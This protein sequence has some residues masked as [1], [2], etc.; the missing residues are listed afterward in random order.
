MKR[1]IIAGLALAVTAG[2][3]GLP[4]AHATFP[5]RN[6]RLVVQA[7]VDDT[8]FP[9]LYDYISVASDWGDF[10]PL[11]SLLGTEPSWSLDGR[12]VVYTAWTDEENHDNVIWRAGA[13]GSDPVR[14]TDS[15]LQE[16]WSEDV[17]PAWAP[18]GSSLVFVRER[19][20]PPYTSKLYAVGTE[21]EDLR[22]LTEGGFLDVQPSWSPDGS[23]I[24]FVRCT[25][26]H[27]HL[28][29][30]S[31][32]I[33]L[34]CEGADLFLIGPDGSNLR[35]LGPP[36]ERSEGHP[37]WSPD[38]RRVVFTCDAD[39]TNR[40][41]G[42]GGLCV[43]NVVTG[44]TRRIYGSANRGMAPLWSPNGRRIIFTV[45]PKTEENNDLEIFSIRP[46]GTGLRRLTDNNK[47]DPVPQQWLAR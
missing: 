6:G 14:L 10:R 18:D 2:T 22:Q 23:S 27:R 20:T 24:V 30:T 45:S 40:K 12:W 4:S 8:E 9:P 26:V 11:A 21:G 44:K 3:I 5:G 28:F 19:A 39:T 16:E 47:D 1:A 31:S 32:P 36:T 46:D 17:Q 43:T 33:P 41:D 7:A 35:P 25:D 42:R 37:D 38:S 15:G 29:F 13:D 34:V